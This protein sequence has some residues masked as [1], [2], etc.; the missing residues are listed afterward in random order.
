MKKSVIVA[1]LKEMLDDTKGAVQNERIWAKGSL[2]DSEEAMM[3]ENNADSLEERVDNLELIIKV[4]EGDADE[5]AFF[6]DAISS[7]L[8]EEELAETEYVEML[9]ELKEQYC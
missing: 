1:N 7:V 3:H 8:E 6:E 2:E 5:D 4:L 9:T